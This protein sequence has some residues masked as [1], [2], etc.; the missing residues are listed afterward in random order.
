MC[1]ISL[2]RLIAITCLSHYSCSLS[3]FSYYMLACMVMVHSIWKL[4]THVLLFSFSA[5]KYLLHF[6]PTVWQIYARS[7]VSNS[8]IWAPHG[9]PMLHNI[10]LKFEMCVY[11][12]QCLKRVTG[13]T[14]VISVILSHNQRNTLQFC[15]EKLE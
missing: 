1:G 13:H 2:H 12:D 8:T 14:G 3:V 9:H 6:K 5:Y 7:T 11:V 10:E 15:S 4:P